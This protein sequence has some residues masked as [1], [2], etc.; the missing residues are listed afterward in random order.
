MADL[1]SSI[2]AFGEK[3]TG[4]DIESQSLIDVLDETTEKYEKSKD[5]TYTAGNGITITE[6]N[7]IN[8]D[9]KVVAYHND[10]T[11]IPSR[12]LESLNIGDVLNFGG[13]YYCVGFKSDLDIRI[14]GF[15][16]NSFISYFY[17]K[18]GKY[19]K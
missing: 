6:D 18:E 10:L 12:V 3:V 8:A 2:K 5:H 4:K 13:T 1:I 15:D 11:K 17:V 14:T 19:Y 7:T 16:S 9:V